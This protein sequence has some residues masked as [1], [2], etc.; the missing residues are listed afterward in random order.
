M[1]HAMILT[2]AMTAGCPMH[3]RHTA[4]VDQR[5]DTFGMSHSESRHTFRLLED[6]GAIELRA[7][8]DDAKTVDAIREHLHTITKDF[9]AGDFSKPYFV[10]ERVPD[11]VETMK[12]LGDAIQYEFEEVKEGARVRITTRNAEA[13]RAVHAFL[14][15]QI[16]D[17]RT[18]DTGTVEKE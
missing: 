3:A 14:R 7:T 15:F 17:H 13:L 16:D 6:G 5:H 10:H 1:I 9:R 12:K 4:G 2:L 18:G 11:G 8:S